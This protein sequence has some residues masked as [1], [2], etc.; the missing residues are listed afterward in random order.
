M[1][2]SDYMYRESL[3][4]NKLSQLAGVNRNTIS[5][6]LKG[7][8]IHRFTS[9]KVSKATNGEVTMLDLGWEGYS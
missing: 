2:L 6:M 8:L 5:K 1:K 4:V 3:S 7:G 9:I